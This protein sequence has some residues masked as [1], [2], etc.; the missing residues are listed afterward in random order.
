MDLRARD[1][2][3]ATFGSIVAEAA[4]GATVVGAPA[5]ESGRAGRLRAAGWLRF[6]ADGTPVATFLFCSAR[7]VRIIT[8]LPRFDWLELEAG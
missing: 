1:D 2:Y 8:F 3:A 5:F 4:K 6:F 7:F